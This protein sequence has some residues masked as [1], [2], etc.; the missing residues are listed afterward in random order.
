M[1]IVPSLFAADAGKLAQEVKDIEDSGA[2]YLHIDI[3]DGHF[4]PN[5]S[6]GPNVLSSLRSKSNLVFDVHLMIQNPLSFCEAFIAAGADIITAHV[7]TNESLDDIYRICAS[8]SVKFGLALCPKTPLNKLTEF[9][10]LLDIM[11]IM[12]VNPGFGGQQFIPQM[13]DRI[14]E[15]SELRKKTDA[16]YLISVDGGVNERISSTIIQAGADILVVGTGVF[17]KEDRKK[18]MMDIVGL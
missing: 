18:A 9:I 14:K 11:L 17:G 5:L 2:K 13:M 8:H 1:F 10:P 16:H 12:G 4:V 15:A 7:E 6:F 3:M